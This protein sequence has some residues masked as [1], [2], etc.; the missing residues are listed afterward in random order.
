MPLR[1]L[2]LSKFLFDMYVEG[3]GVLPPTK[4]RHAVGMILL[5]MCCNVTDWVWKFLLFPLL[6]KSRISR[7]KEFSN[8]WNDKQ[9]QTAVKYVL[10]LWC[11]GNV[12]VTLTRDSFRNAVARAHRRISS[13]VQLFI[14]GREIRRTLPSRGDDKSSRIHLQ[15]SDWRHGLAV[16][17]A[18]VWYLLVI[19]VCLSASLMALLLAQGC[20]QL[21]GESN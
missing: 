8:A 12:G 14:W 17:C 3:N 4:Q 18:C 1:C 10:V 15:P 20:Q 16:S 21:L 19:F 13:V 9:P 5:W 11:V 7:F 6:R 2:V